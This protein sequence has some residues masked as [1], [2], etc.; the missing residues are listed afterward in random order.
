MRLHV[1]HALA[2]QVGS[3]AAV[4]EERL[5]FLGRAAVAGDQALVGGDDIGG[6]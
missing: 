1:S 6:S 3:Q 2:G 5:G 4:P